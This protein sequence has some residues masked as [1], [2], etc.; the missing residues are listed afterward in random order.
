MSTS[1][2]LRILVADDHP[3]TATTFGKVLEKRG[4]TAEIAY[5]GLSA[6]DAVLQFQPHV[7]LL[8]INMPGL[9]GHELTRRI[10][11]Q[12]G[13]ESIV[14]VIVSGDGQADTVDKSLAAG[15]DHHLTKPVDF[16]ALWHIL[17]D[18][19]RSLFGP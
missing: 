5:D 8:D 4:H 18:T 7:A 17:D 15:A 13:C 14:V 6:L 3:G 9:D 2:S 19:I 1:R 11:V 12:P 16:D 10:R